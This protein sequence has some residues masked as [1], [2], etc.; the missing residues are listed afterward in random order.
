M[1]HGKKHCNK[2]RVKKFGTWSFDIF[3]PKTIKQGSHHQID[4]HPIPAPKD[5]KYKCL[6]HTIEHALEEGRKKENLHNYNLLE[7]K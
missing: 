2:K 4:P 7:K 1:K 5:F 3:R 6:K